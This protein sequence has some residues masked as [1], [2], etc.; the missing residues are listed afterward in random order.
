MRRL[1]ALCAA[2]CFLFVGCGPTSSRPLLWY[3]DTLTEIT[4]C[5]GD[6][7]WR[8][9]P[10]PGGYTAEILAPASI[11]G[12]TITVTDTA[13]QI[14]LGEVR[15]PVSRAITEK[16]DTL[17][18]LLSLTEEE[19]IG[20]NAPG[21]DPEG[22]TCA[23]FRRDEAEITAGLNTDGLPAYFDRTVD[24]ITERIFVTDIQ[25]GND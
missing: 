13:S 9:T 21:D 4:L 15:I 2:L 8:M 11:A 23:R 18:S 3:Q 10:I 24:G 17:F 22:I 5:E 20:V 12:I 6:T 7:T 19:L 25:Y 16:C 14:H 1:F